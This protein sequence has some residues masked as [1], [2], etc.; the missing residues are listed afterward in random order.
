MDE[1]ILLQVIKPARYTGGEWNAARKDFDAARV[2]FALCFPDLYEVGMSNL[3]LRVL[4][5]VL[6]AQDGVVC[7]R[8]FSPGLDMEEKIRQGRR[9]F[10][11]LEH[12][13]T[14]GEFDLIGFSLGYELVYTNVLAV[15]DLGHIPLESKGRGA[16]HPL[17]IGGGTCALNPEPIADFFDLFVIGEGEEVL[18]EIVELYRI[19][20]DRFKSGALSRPALLELLA[21]IEGVYVPSLYEVRYDSAGSIQEIRPKTAALAMPVRKRFVGDFDASF[22]P[23]DWVVPYIEVIHDRVTLE[24]MRG[25]PNSCRFC[26][27]RVQ[28]HPAR[29]RS[30]ETIMR[31]ARQVYERS[32]YEEMSLTGLSVS[33]YPDLETLVKNLIETFRQQCVSISLPSI[34]PNKFVGALSGDIART[35]KTGLTFAPE[36]GSDRMRRVLNKQFDVPTFLGVLAQAYRAGYQRVKLYFMIGLPFETEQDLDGILELASA[37]SEAKRKETGSPAQVNV[38]INAL[39]PKP[40]TAFQWLAMESSASIRSKQEYLAKKNRNR[41]V[42]LRFHNDRMAYVEGVFSRGDRRLAPAVLA[43]FKSGCR[44]DAWD[45]YFS[46]EKWAQALRSC[47]VD[48]EFYLGARPLDAVLPWDAVDAGIGKEALIVEY[49]KC[50]AAK[51]VREYNEE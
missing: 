7:D 9:P 45:S 8:F 49:K 23:V 41:R 40:H 36:A 22:F 33:D 26:Q 15:L 37:V 2:K 46:F 11:S 21:Q 19:H 5:G 4:Y 12:Q 43:A 30:P 42:T 3:G 13:K 31:L 10:W 51:E 29:R 28:Y 38:S 34:K 39:V 35:K 14:P 27:A 24:I 48:P 50:V 32:G 1:D 20:R 16:A 17:V 47:G 44:F 18:L 25:C 6:N